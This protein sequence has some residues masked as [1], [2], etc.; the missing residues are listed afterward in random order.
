MSS[1][2]R[3]SF[4]V[5]L[6]HHPEFTHTRTHTP[7]PLV[8]LVSLTVQSSQQT[9]KPG[10]S[11]SPSVSIIHI[12][13][14]QMRLASLYLW[15]NLTQAASS[16]SFFLTDCT[17]PNIPEGRGRLYLCLLV[18]SLSTPLFL[19]YEAAVHKTPQWTSQTPQWTSQI[20]GYMVCRQRAICLAESP[21]CTVTCCHNATRT[22][23]C[24]PFLFLASH[25]TRACDGL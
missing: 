21:Y 12:S 4:I 20:R 2:Q 13:V 3:D 19:F 25:C 8:L 9:V 18:L 24:L 23:T 11:G 17:F 5:T 10:R 22:C 14:R 16:V 6:L 15:R 1:Q 7:P